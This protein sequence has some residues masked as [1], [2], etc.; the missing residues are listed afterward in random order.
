[1]ATL[2]AWE[3]TVV[4]LTSLLDD[5]R[6]RRGTRTGRRA[7]TARSSSTTPNAPT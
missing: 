7:L 6:R 2:P 4:F 1:M 3:R 5:E